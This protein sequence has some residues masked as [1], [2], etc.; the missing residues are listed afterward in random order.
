VPDVPFES[1]EP[2]TL[3]IEEEFL[4][5]E[6][7]DGATVAPRAQALLD[8]EL[9]TIA[10]PG[11]WIKPEL[12]LG[13]IEVA[14]APNRDLLQLDVDLRALRDAVVERAAAAGAVVAGIGMH[15]DLVATDE[16]VTPT[17]AHRA[18][19]SLHERIGTLGDQVTHG[20]HVHVGMPSLDDAVRVMDALAGCVPLFVALTANSPVVRGRRAPW[21]S[22]RSEVQ[23]RMLWAGPTPRIAGIDEYRTIHALHQLENSGDQRFLWDVAPV[24]QLGTVEVR[25]FD[26]HADPAVALGMAALVQAIAAHVLEGGALARPI[27][28]LER[29]NRWSA[30]E[31]GVRARFLVA[32]RD[33]PVDAA[34]LVHELVELVA[35]RAQ[36]LRNDPW[37]A[38]IDDLLAAPPV[39]AGIAAFES[40]GVRALLEGSL[41]SGAAPDRDDA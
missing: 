37:L 5:L 1:S 41:L 36:E 13:S 35:P 18:I 32:G 39:E 29:H 31:F 7:D 12:L 6:S 24:P 4:L 17:E 14:T 26:A 25:S 9:R 21:K 10:S 3:G 30:M 27:E 2:L 38:I 22:A 8:G 40:G 15:P 11:G 28:S 23:R 33:S 16:L 34:D 20:I 19:A